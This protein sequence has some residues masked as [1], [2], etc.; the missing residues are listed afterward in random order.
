MD[1]E[2]NMNY[3]ITCDIANSFDECTVSDIDLSK[4]RISVTGDDTFSWIDDGSK[5][6]STFSILPEKN[7]PSVY[8][9][10]EQREKH[11]KYPALQK[12]WEDYVNMYN[13]TE[14]EPPI[15]E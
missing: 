5:Y 9:S 14:G 3:Q 6:D 2:D 13:L 1:P 10:F 15:V 7:N 8:T 12:A 4:Y 11:N